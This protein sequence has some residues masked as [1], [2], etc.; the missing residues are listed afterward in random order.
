MSP[1]VRK[2]G[3]GET[4]TC[5]WCSATVPAEAT[6]CPSCDASLRDAAD[7]DILGVTQVDPAAVA[8]ARRIRSPRNIVAFLGVGD[9]PAEDEPI[10]KVEPPSDEVRQEMLRLELAALDA[11]IEA[12][13]KEASAQQALPRGGDPK[14]KPD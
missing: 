2:R 12:K 6:T 4:A 7:G 3:R 13:F 9:G 1:A 8:R 11:E 14:A 5:P 10:G